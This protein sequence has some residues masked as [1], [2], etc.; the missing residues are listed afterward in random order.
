[1]QRELG[2]LPCCGL[3]HGRSLDRDGV[4]LDLGDPRAGCRCCAARCRPS[5]PEPEAPSRNC[6]TDAD[7]D[8]ATAA[9]RV[10]GF[11]TVIARSGRVVNVA[12]KVIS[13]KHSAHNDCESPVV[14]MSKPAASASRNQRRYSSKWCGVVPVPNRTAG[15]G[16]GSRYDA[17]MMRTVTR[18]TCPRCEREFGKANQAHTCLPGI[19]VDECFSGRPPWQRAIFAAIADHLETLG[20]VHYDAVH[21]GV[22]LKHVQKFAE[23]RPKVRSVSLELVLPRTVDSPRVAKHITIASERIVHIVKLTDEAQVDRELRAWLSESYAAGSV[24]E[25]KAGE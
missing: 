5:E 15:A 16:M 25:R 14:S 24:P 20:P 2:T 10:I 8:A 19:T 21:V 1:M 3:P 17:G 12:A 9:W 7:A 13:E 6:C 11:D 18:W 4:V 23:V 22:F